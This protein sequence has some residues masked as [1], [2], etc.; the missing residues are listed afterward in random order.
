MPTDNRILDDL[1][2]VAA[3]AFSAM[4][5]LRDEVEARTREQFERIIARLDLVKREEF[6]AVKEMAAKAREAQE[7]LEARLAALEAR[8]PAA[9][10]P[11]RKRVAKP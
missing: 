10:R 8:Q 3:G 2:R 11:A 7:A 5:G 4:S 9:P 6:E 1:S